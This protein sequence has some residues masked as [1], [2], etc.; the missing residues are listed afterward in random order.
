MSNSCVFCK[1]ICGEIPC[2]K[3]YENDHCIVILD[4]AED[5]DGHMLA[6]PKNHVKNILDCDRKTLHELTDTVKL[7]SEHLVNH[8]GYD[9]INLLNANDE[10][11]G[12]SIPHFH[13]HLIPRKSGDN[14]DAWPVFEGITLT[15]D[16]MF[17]KLKI[18]NNKNRRACNDNQNN[19]YGR[20]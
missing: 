19:E 5:V 15:L 16:E 14:I 2:K 20:L 7:V 4:T 17:P 10:S 1:I 18:D 13:I 3:I 9:G 6:L 11:A 12:Q 8:C